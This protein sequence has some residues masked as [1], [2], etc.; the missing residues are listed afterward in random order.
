MEASRGRGSSRVQ[1]VMDG[2]CATR[3]AKDLS[4]IRHLPCACEIR[5]DR[6]ALQVQ[7]EVESRQNLSHLQYAVEID[8]SNLGEFQRVFENPG[9]QIV[10]PCFARVRT[11]GQEERLRG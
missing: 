8:S 10:V 5:G 11:D 3:L 6:C 4:D 1:V 7:R 9:H 2:I